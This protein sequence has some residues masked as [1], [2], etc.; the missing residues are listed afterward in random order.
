MEKDSNTT[1]SYDVI[2]IGAGSA[3]L[4]VAGFMNS[5]GFKVLLIDK[6]FYMLP[7]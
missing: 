1:K 4:N 3:G 5:A 7:N 6:R 2:V